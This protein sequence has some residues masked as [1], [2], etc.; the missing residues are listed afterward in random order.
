MAQGKFSENL[1]KLKCNLC[2]KI[3]YFT[4]KNRKTVTNKLSLKKYCKNCRKHTIHNE[5]KK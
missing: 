2:Q 3:N 1:I 5:V 4:R